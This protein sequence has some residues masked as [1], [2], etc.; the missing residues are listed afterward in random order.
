ML[1]SLFAASQKMCCADL[2]AARSEVFLIQCLKDHIRIRRLQKCFFAAAILRFTLLQTAPGV[3]FRK[4]FA[5]IFGSAPVALG[6]AEVL[7]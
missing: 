7:S 4:T 6:F 5:Q 2:H 3:L 1:L